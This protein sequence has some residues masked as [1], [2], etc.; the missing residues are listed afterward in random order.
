VAINRKTNAVVPLADANPA[1]AVTAADGHDAIAR[2]IRR[3]LLPFLFVL[4]VIA[5]LD[6]IN[7]GFAALTMNHEL[8]LGGEQYGL[9]SGIFFWGYFLFEVPSNLILERIGARVWIARILISWGVVSLATAFA[10]SAQQLYLARFLLGVAEAGFFPG[11]LMYLTYW[12]RQRDMS[13]AIGFFMTA[14]PT[15]SIVG[16]PLSGWILDHVHAF[17]LSSWRWVL[18][19]EA[20]P[21][22]I[23]GALCY[24]ILPN[25]PGEA[26]FLTQAHKASIASALRVEAGFKSSTHRDSVLSTL[27]DPRVLYLA[28][29]AFLFMIGNYV[30]GFWMPQ[31]IKAVG[32][33][34]SHLT[35]GLLVMVPNVVGFCGMVLVSRS[36]S[37][38]GECHWHAALSLISA[39][40]AFCFVGT[41]TTLPTCILLW[42]VATS[43]LY[44][45]IGPFWSMPGR[46]L[47]GRATAVALAA[48][49]SIGNLAGFVGLAAI[50]AMASRAGGLADG[51]RFIALALALGAALL[52]AQRWR[53]TYGVTTKPLYI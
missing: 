43:G 19:L 33:G 25:G 24:L 29:I 48:I 35:I 42:S 40:T 26:R 47:T 44:G 23:G 10:H 18:I 22:I 6:R 14:L 50:G 17:G 46:F 30:T 28:A 1:A 7:I 38:R 53:D 45:F 2:I 5:Y 51:F 4:Y 11:M 8:G 32:H 31:S 49:C 21:A 15:A 13:Q 16:G 39:A 20:L 9:L 34:L 41:A 37:R 52:L 27:K 3:H 36:S 12:F